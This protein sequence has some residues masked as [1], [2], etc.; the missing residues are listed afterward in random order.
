M[1]SLIEEASTIQKAVEKAWVRAG[2]PAEFTVKI[3]EEPKHNFLGMTTKSAKVAI[4]FKAPGQAPAQATPERRDSSNYNAPRDQNRRQERSSGDY[5][6]RSGRA[7]APEQSRE[8]QDQRRP[9][10]PAHDQRT[11]SS[12]PVNH[13]RPAPSERTPDRREQRTER[14]YERP[15]ERNISVSKDYAGHGDRPTSTE[16]SERPGSSERMNDRPEDRSSDRGG[17]RYADRSR[18]PDTR[19]GRPGER[20]RVD[21]VW[22]NEMADIAQDWLENMLGMLD[23][24]EALAHVKVVG[25]NL[26]FEF[27]QP[28]LDDKEKERVL[29]A[30]FTHLML[31]TVGNKYK[32]DLRGL[33]IILAHEE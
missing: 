13:Q 26:K 17:D 24:R 21:A 15:A 11:E 7:A 2:K 19:R 16:R 25:E 22:S 5:Q 27:K 32:K 1:K 9:T 3:F 18:R 31:A 28:L 23:K 14:P 8:R 12:A 29:F 6:S 20:E 10:R 33:R 30:S 4:F